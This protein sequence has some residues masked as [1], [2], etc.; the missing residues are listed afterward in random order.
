MRLDQKI[1]VNCTNTDKDAEAVIVRIQKGSIDVSISN[2]I[3]KLY[4]KRPGFYVGN[5]HGLEFTTSI[6]L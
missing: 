6:K 4:L 2:A 1:I 3:V 5:M